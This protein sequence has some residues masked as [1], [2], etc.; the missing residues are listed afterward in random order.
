MQEHQLCAK[1]LVLLVQI[2]FLISVLILVSLQVLVIVLDLVQQPMV[3]FAPRSMYALLDCTSGMLT[4]HS[5]S[6]RLIFV[7]GSYPLS[8]VIAVHP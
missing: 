4:F 8:F 2:H 3:G 6:A 1:P 5:S 7:L